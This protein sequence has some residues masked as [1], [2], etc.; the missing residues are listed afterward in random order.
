M[1][2][3]KKKRD[4]KA[5]PLTEGAS[6]YTKKSSIVDDKRDNDESKEELL[7]RIIRQLQDGETRYLPS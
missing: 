5:F 4:R 3:T 7:Q 2:K 6:G 1:G